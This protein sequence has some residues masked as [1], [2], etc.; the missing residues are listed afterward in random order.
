LQLNRLELTRFNQINSIESK[1]TSWP[2]FKLFRPK[3]SPNWTKNGKNWKFLALL[4]SLN[5]KCYIVLIGSFVFDVQIQLIFK[6]IF[7]MSLSYLFSN[8]FWKNFAKTKQPVIS[9]TIPNFENK[10]IPIFAK[11]QNSEN[12]VF[13]SA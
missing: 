2:N 13:R 4:L 8:L 3:L 10:I 11:V 5:T 1:M 7:V 12:F 6:F 9:K